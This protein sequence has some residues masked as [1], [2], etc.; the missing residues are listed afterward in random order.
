M[1]TGRPENISSENTDSLN[2]ISIK[3]VPA[4]NWLRLTNLLI[5]YLGFLVLGVV[6][7]V[8]CGIFL[9]EETLNRILKIPDLVLGIPL[10]VFYYIFFE[11][12]YGRT[13]GKFITRTKVVNEDGGNAS[14]LQI[15]GRT[16]CRF[17]P[18]EPF[19]F[20]SKKILAFMIGLQK[21]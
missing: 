10:L 19:T 20:L 5:D 15:T 8:F 4:S 11:A 21:R 7:G 18:F 13:P 1:S 12:L 3:L 14:F 6:M 9:T 17:I 2:L 16:L